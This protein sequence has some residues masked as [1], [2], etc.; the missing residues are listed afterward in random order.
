MDKQKGWLRLGVILTAAGMIFL[1]AGAASSDTAK[2]LTSEDLVRTLLF[3]QTGRVLRQPQP[4]MPVTQVPVT[5]IQTPE[6][7]QPPEVHEPT[8]PE[9]VAPSQETVAA[10]LEAVEVYNQTDCLLE[11]TALWE[12]A[13]AVELSGAQPSVLILHTHGSESYENTE[14]YTPEGAYRTLQEE[15]NMVSIGQQVAQRLE[16]AGIAVI[17]DRTMHDQPS[18]SGSY[19]HA[20][21]A[22]A[23]YLE[24]Y[25]SIR[26][27]LD[28]H[29]DAAPSG[30]QLR[31]V[32]ETQRGT[33]AQLMLVLGT[34]S[35]GLNHPNWQDNLALGVR[36]QAILEGL[37]PGLCRPLNVRS[38]RFNQD[39]SEGALLIEVGAT[40]NTREQALLAADYLA[41]GILC[42]AEQ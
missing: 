30:K 12:R 5:Q 14:Q 8:E 34:D 38:Q 20:R 13:E 19:A 7:T 27:V 31:P 11:M 25:P 42:L 6:V 18:Y 37:C 33:A 26:L 3:L 23:D 21:Q 2:A 15:Y 40:G 28:L 10:R 32:V 24:T 36:L 22:I 29:R 17:H 41:E 39:L 4:Q 16:Q 9:S 35:G 1:L